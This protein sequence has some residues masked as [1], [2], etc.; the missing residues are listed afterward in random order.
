MTVNGP[1]DDDL[2]W[3][4]IVWTRHEDNVRRLRRRIFKATKAGDLATVR[5]LQKTRLKRPRGLLEP[6]AATSGTYGSEGAPVQ[7]C[8]GATRLLPGG[9]S[10]RALAEGLSSRVVRPSA[11]GGGSH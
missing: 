11:G 1:E 7:Q 3:D 10:Q 4:A 5:N 9:W 2:D 6:Y 8:T